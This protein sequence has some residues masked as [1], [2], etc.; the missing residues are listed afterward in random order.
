M[1]FERSSGIFLHPTSLPSKYGIGALGQAAYDFIDFLNESGQKLWQICP[2]GPTGFGDSPYQCFSAFAGNPIL[3][4]LEKL[5][6]A[7]YLLKED[8]HVEQEFADDEVEYGKVINFK[9]PLFNKAFKRFREVAPSKEEDEFI[10]FCQDNIEWLENYALFMA[11]K[12]YFDGSPWTKWDDDIKFR[13]STAIDKYKA[14]LKEKMD[15]HKFMQYIFFKQWADV[16]E[17]ANQNNIQII[18][19]IPIFVAFDSADAWANPHLFL[20]NEQKEPTKVAGVPPDYFNENGQLWGNPLYD[21]DK[22]EKNNYSWWI[23]RVKSQLELV[24]II[25]FDHFRGFSQYWAVPADATTAINGQ[26]K[27]GP[28]KEL[29]KTIKDELGEL[30]IIVEDLG[31]ITEDVE[32]LRDY[33]GFPGMKILQFAF[34][35]KEENDY[36]PH[37][38]SENCV[39]YTGTHDNNTTLG[40]YQDDAIEKDK[41]DMLKYLDKHLAKEDR[42]DN[43]VWDLLELAWGSVAVFAIAPLQDILCLDS[44]ARMN[45][46]GTSSGNWRWRYREDMLTENLQEELSK[47]TTKH[48]NGLKHS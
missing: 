42:H 40:W 13:K 31:V 10:A 47:M 22:L 8:L 39:V 32:E 46:P 43:I 24:D 6:E 44:E 16:K 12:D 34:D 33:F 25:R 38:Y 28:G 7:G 17:Y 29:F 14:K 11:L 26:W 4:D 19:D 36:T 3:I 23:N 35:S 48:R 37:E 15:F 41:K 9:Y 27:D 5:R 18:G 20:F 21:W 2:L 1:R 30:P 45:I